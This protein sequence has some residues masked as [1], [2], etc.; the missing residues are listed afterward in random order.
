MMRELKWLLMEW[1]LSFSF[2]TNENKRRAANFCEFNNVNYYYQGA[3]N[4]YTSFQ[5]RREYILS[6]LVKKVPL[7][8][9]LK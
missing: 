8:D 7:F 6:R 2:F 3:S 4:E 9:G 1:K 5:T